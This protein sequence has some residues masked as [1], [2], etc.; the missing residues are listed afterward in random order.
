MIRYGGKKRGSA[1]LH[2][3]DGICSEKNISKK[4]RDKSKKRTL[5]KIRNGLDSWCKIIGGC[6]A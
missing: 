1:K 2:D 6:Y 3:H 5:R 4:Q